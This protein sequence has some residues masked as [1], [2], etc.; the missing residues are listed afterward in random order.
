MIAIA[1]NDSLNHICLC[2]YDGEDLS[3]VKVDYV[4][5]LSYAFHDRKGTVNIS[6]WNTG[7]VENMDY[8]FH[9]SDHIDGI[10]ELDVSNVKELTGVFDSYKGTADI[11]KWE[12][13]NPEIYNNIINSLNKEKMAT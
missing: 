10:G 5:D 9:N 4:T 2:A 1:D 12:Q 8:A 13:I 11:S 7:H 6:K 3:Y